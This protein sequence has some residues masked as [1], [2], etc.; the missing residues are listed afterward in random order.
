M[1]ADRRG[2][3][4]RSGGSRPPQPGTGPAARRQAPR[5][6]Q[7]G[8]RDKQSP[9]GRSG[10]ARY[11]PR[12]SELRDDRND[13]A[14]RSPES[15][16]A[17]PDRGPRESARPGLARSA[18]EPILPPDVD[19]RSLHR[20]VRAELRSLP[21]DLAEIVAGH[22]V[23]AGQLID[24][25][26]ELAYAHAEAARRRAARLPIVRE[27]AAETAYA[28]GRYDVA[29]SEFRALRRMTGTD[30]YLPVM[31]DCER[32]LGRPQ[33]ALKLAKEAARR[34]LDPALRIEMTI[35]EAGRPGRPGPGRRGAPDSGPG[36]THRRP[37]RRWRTRTPGCSTRTPTCCCATGQQAEARQAFARAAALDT[38]QQTDAQQRVDE[39]DGFLIE[40]D[41]EPESEDEATVGGRGHRRLR[42]GTLRPGRSGLPGAGG[43][44][45]GGGGDRRPAGAEDPG[46]LRHQQR[47]PAAGRG[48]RA[49]GRAGHP[50][51][52]ERR[53]RRRPRPVRTWCSTGSVRG[54]R[55]LVVGGEG[56]A[57]G[58][59][60]GRVWSGSASADDGPVAVLAGLGV[61]ADLAAAER[62]GDRHPPRRSLGGHQ[63][64]PHPTDRPRAGARQRGRGGR[65]GHGGSGHVRRS[66][67]SRYRPLLDDT[68]AR[69]GAGRPVFVG[70]RLDTDIA[71]AVNAGLD[72]MLVLT[73]SHGAADL[74][75]PAR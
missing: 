36:R 18:N 17:P 33:D 67:A 66:P 63:H 71:G 22:L 8:R 70:D 41:D 48:R 45:R 1:A 34:P 21:K 5:G 59:R 20:A 73:G 50:G 27:A 42:R 75:S 65:R 55:V 6:D 11:D 3:R 68:V 19:T 26:P 14:R 7:A 31:A 60:R 40:F 69:L 28:A 9:S 61:R 49:P 25:E 52:A 62:G 38:E 37:G 35:V 51:E 13:Q 46:R 24:E 56:V 58:A 12:K 74:L 43:G 4:P 44:A 54:A 64:R 57:D 10:P 15:R 30:D 47:R 29:L 23:L 39:L 53:G 32:A 2:K 16:S 72:S